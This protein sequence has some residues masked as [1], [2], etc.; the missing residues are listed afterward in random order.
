MVLLR[1]CLVAATLCLGACGGGTAPGPSLTL[2]QL[3]VNVSA[4]T[5]S[6]SAPFATVDATIANVTGTVYAGGLF[7]K[8]GLWLASVSRNDATHFSL[9]LQFRDPPTLSPGAY[10]DTISVHL[11]SDQACATV[12]SA[13]QVIMTHYVVT[14]TAIPRP[15]VTI[16]T[17]TINQQTLSFVPAAQA[18]IPLTFQNLASL[19]V[20]DQSTTTNNAIQGI[21]YFGPGGATGSIAVTFKPSLPK[22]TY[23]DV[24]TLSF[25][26]SDTTYCQEVISGSGAT[27]AVTLTVADTITGANGYSVKF[28]PVSA[29]GLVWDP[30]RQL[31]YA[32]SRSDS[33][34]SPQSVV[35]I[36]P[37]TGS[38]VKS[39]TLG[40]GSGKLAISR[41][42]NYL[43]AGQDAASTVM[44]LA[45]PAVS[46][47]LTLQLPTDPFTTGMLRAKSIEVSPDDAH[48]I[49]VAV[50]KPVQ[51]SPNCY[52]L[53]LFADAQVR[54]SLP[55]RGTDAEPCS[56]SVQWGANGSVL[57]A[58]DVGSFPFDIYRIAVDANG[59]TSSLMIPGDSLM[60]MGPIQYRSGL[61]YMASGVIY[62]TVAGTVLGQVPHPANTLQRGVFS[63]ETHRVL[64][65][66]DT[67][68]G[69]DSIRI[70]AYDTTTYA[71]I[72][73]IDLPHLSV[74]QLP[75]GFSRSESAA[76]NAIRWGAD[77]YAVPLVDGRVLLIKGAFVGP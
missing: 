61:L 41:D 17:A 59:M 42:G 69:L 49:A 23:Q 4:D 38:V 11:C 37:L 3:S 53:M 58:D 35:A 76:W 13:T 39:V 56:S 22:G 52:S 36:D 43:Y 74:Q 75:N 6:Q 51:Y 44:R 15:R 57:Y 63:P 60:Y 27:V 67:V 25:C 71:E 1:A 14:G 28:A 30:M 68:L 31:I 20:T 5:S 50:S 46:P 24:V 48:L 73:H 66:D 29:D 34:T 65:I 10:D 47:D 12:V 40:G 64:A 55:G 18:N 16:G 32:S 45:L 54:A 77:G 70:T 2:S 21:M 33:P 62:D 7:S 8:S 19:R 26:N 9:T 72:A